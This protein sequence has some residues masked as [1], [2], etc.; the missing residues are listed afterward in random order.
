MSL[1]EHLEEY[2]EQGYTIFRDYLPKETIATLRAQ[3][4]PYF[5]ELIAKKQPGKGGFWQAAKVGGR[6][7]V[8]LAPAIGPE[9]AE[10]GM[11]P[12]LEGLLGTD[13]LLRF[14]EMVMGPAVQLDSMEFT[15]YPHRGEESNTSGLENGPVYGWHRDPFAVSTNYNAHPRVTSG[16]TELAA[17]KPYSP[18]LACNILH[19]LQDMDDTTGQLRV[20]P[21]SHRDYS[22]VPTDPEQLQQPIPG[23]VLVNISAGDMI[24]THCEILHAGTVNMSP[25]TR[26]FVSIYLTRSGLPHRDSFDNEQVHELCAKWRAAVS[27]HGCDRSARLLRLIPGTPENAALPE[28]EARVWALGQAALAEEEAQQAL[29]TAPRL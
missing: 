16:E 5:E 9:L 21:G 29:R 10:R 25:L 18:P 24:W 14:A 20:L 19:Y 15:G 6:G 3:A 4:E 12:A 13:T 8:A 23:E 27:S 28:R 1:E 11:L 22:P 26:Y 17:P 7:R 2:M